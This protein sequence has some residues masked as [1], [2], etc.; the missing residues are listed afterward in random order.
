MYWTITGLI[1]INGL[2]YTIEFF[3]AIIQCSPR[4]R[5]WNKKLPGKCIG[6]SNIIWT[7]G[8]NIITD[9]LIIILPLTCIWRL[10]MS[11]KK[12][13][14]VSVIFSTGFMYNPTCS[15]WHF[16]ADLTSA[17]AASVLRLYYS[18]YV[19]H[20]N[21]HS[22]YYL[23]LGFCLYEVSSPP[24]KR[25][26]YAQGADLLQYRTLECVAG[27]VVGCMPTLP[28]FSTSMKESWSNSRFRLLSGRSGS[29]RT[30]SDSRYR[31]SDNAANAYRKSAKGNAIQ[32]QD[33]L[34][35]LDEAH[36]TCPR[37]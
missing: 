17:V 2:F 33:S 30:L 15:T 12:K 29:E 10:Q 8:F 7:A 36:L 16:K 4:A 13:I 31:R 22:Y 20:T 9:I 18:H 11:L 32:L 24:P 35:D 25:S 34:A 23:V 37:F 6:S 27:I 21:D 26:S 1:S 14:G 19:L 5:S 3:L 28:R